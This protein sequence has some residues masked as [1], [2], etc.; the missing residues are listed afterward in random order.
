MFTMIAMQSRSYR[1]VPNNYTVATP[2]AYAD[3]IQVR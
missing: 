2:I 1:L 3:S